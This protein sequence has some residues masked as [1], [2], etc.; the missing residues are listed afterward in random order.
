[1]IK[2]IFIGLGIAII[3]FNLI[4]V[5]CCIRIGDEDNE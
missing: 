1:M 3:L 2:W 5:W 4:V